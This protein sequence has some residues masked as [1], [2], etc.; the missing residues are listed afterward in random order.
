[1]SL[2]KT[3]LTQC[4][5]YFHRHTDWSRFMTWYN[6]QVEKA[7]SV[8]ST[9]A[10]TSKTKRLALG[11][12]ISLTI[13]YSVYRHVSRPPRQLR[14]IP[15]I[16]FFTFSRR[17]IISKWTTAKLA[18]EFELPLLKDGN[19]M[20]VRS[21]KFGWTVH[22][23]TPDAAK[24][25]FLK[26]DLFPKAN[27][28]SANA[29]IIYRLVGTSNIVFENGDEWRKHRKLVNPAFH[30]SM[31]I[32]VFGQVAQQVFTHL[33]KTQPNDFTLDFGQLT[34][35]ITIDVIGRAGFGFDFN[36]VLDDASPWKQ[37]YDTVINGHRDPLYMML[38]SLEK[39]FLWMLPKRQRIHAIT[40]KFLTMLQQ[41]ID[42]KRLTLRE[43][44]ATADDIDDSEKDLL[45]LMLESELRGEGVLTDRELLNDIGIFF[46]AGHDTTSTALTAA[47]YYLAKHPD[48]QEKA[49]QEVIGILCPD[50]MEP[51]IDILPTAD[52]V[53]KFNYL[54]QV[55]KETLRI[56]GPVVS[57]V[58]PRLTTNDVTLSNVLI[59]KD[60][61]VNVN[62]Y[63]L[64]HNPN[65]WMKPDVF[66]PERFAPGGEADQ[67]A[68]GGMA[69][70]P[71]A[72]GQRMCVGNMFSINE[73]RVLLACLLRKYQWTL[74]TDSIHK[75]ELITTNSNLMIPQDV[76][77]RF[78]KK[79]Y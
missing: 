2:I 26:S 40:T 10:P 16:N 27:Q 70:I 3:T 15:Y 51:P 41:I 13:L 22:V 78:Y 47:V 33:D 69:W 30:R 14:H 39:Y 34:E 72:N 65:V 7:T 6:E 63:D 74:P 4:S 67:Q 64:H 35:R 49:R 23:C 79:R 50:G 59:P 53:K 45:T 62:I 43:K 5:D 12:A 31:P 76:R 24:K 1:M 18:R 56:N 29:S 77:I 37:V 68:G 11:V 60:T 25:V 28:S 36:S 42:N 71:F 73:Q 21:D 58:S 48:I 20:F 44:Y 46:I 75:E 55:I 9:T 61:L 52:Q 66:D 32:Q 17:F 38:P 19:P 57:L 8:A 54:N